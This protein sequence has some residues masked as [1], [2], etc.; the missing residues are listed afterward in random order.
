M[1]KIGDRVAFTIV[2]G[3]TKFP[4]VI[5]DIANR[6][7]AEPI[8]LEHLNRP[9][10]K[11]YTFESLEMD[12]KPWIEFL[13]HEVTIELLPEANDLLKDLVNVSS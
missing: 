6:Y 5:I 3:T 12:T 8:G 11:A 2:N 1:F 7:Y 13:E 4:A 10:V 9:P